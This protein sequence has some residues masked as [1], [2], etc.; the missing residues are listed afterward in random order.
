MSNLQT[1]KKRF[2][3]E[4]YVMI[5]DFFSKEEIET[6]IHDIRETSDKKQKRIS[7]MSAIYSSTHYSCTK[8]KNYGNLFRNQKLLIF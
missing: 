7:L 3:K 4:G 5:K 8:A 6:L 2:N 1:L